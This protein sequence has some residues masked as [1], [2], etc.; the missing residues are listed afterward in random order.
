[1]KNRIFF[2][3]LL[4][5]L[6]ASCGEK[7]PPELKN[8]SEEFDYVWH[9]LDANYPYFDYVTLDMDSAYRKY[10]RIAKKVTHPYNFGILMSAFSLEFGDPNVDIRFPDK[11]QGTPYR[12]STK[13]YPA[14]NLFPNE[15]YIGGQINEESAS[16]ECTNIGPMLFKQV[17]RPTD[18]GRKTYPLI[19]CSGAN[20]V[21]EIAKQQLFQ[22]LSSLSTSSVE[23]LVLDLRCNRNIDTEFIQKLLPYFYEAGSHQ[24]YEYRSN[25]STADET[26]AIEG[27]GV[28]ANMPIAVIV[29]ESTIGECS[30][31]ARILKPRSNVA[32]IGRANAGPGCLRTLSDEYEGVAVKYPSA[33]IETFYDPLVPEVFVEWE[34]SDDTVLASKGYTIDYCLAAALDFIDAQ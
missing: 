14:I 30:W 13:D 26:Y 18:L 27:N 11:A 17:Y 7:N 32:I 4:V 20:R 6:F 9:V 16:G 19:V 2:F 21:S 33:R 8:Y 10:M 25:T 28:L 12:L 29:N 22:A 5:G 15:L 31:F 24:L 34:G 3:A 23:G 1:M